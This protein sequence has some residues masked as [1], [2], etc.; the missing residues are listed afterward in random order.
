MD[1][2]D[3]RLSPPS[4]SR[5]SPSLRSLAYLV[6]NLNLSAYSVRSI[7]A[8]DVP[9]GGR[10]GLPAQ[11]VQVV[12]VNGEVGAGYF[13]F[14][15]LGFGEVGQFVFLFPLHPPVLKPYLNLSLGEVQR[16]RD[17][18]PAPARQVSVEVEF[19][20]EFQRLMTC[21]RRAGTLAFHAVNIVC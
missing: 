14:L 1:G 16:M 7:L 17:L 13:E 10:S 20:L 18:D 12:V 21:V 4:L 19:L 6:L 2:R 3:T 11:L 15:G 5:S 9:P 8:S